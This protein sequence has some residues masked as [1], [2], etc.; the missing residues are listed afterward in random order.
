M[1]SRLTIVAFCCIIPRYCHCLV[2]LHH[3][4]FQNE[5]EASSLI[6]QHLS[7]GGGTV[8]LLEKLVREIPPMRYTVENF[9]WFGFLR[10]VPVSHHT[11]KM[12]CCNESTLHGKCSFHSRRVVANVRFVTYNLVELLLFHSVKSCAVVCIFV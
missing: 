7:A 11:T 12:P 4:L 2:L 3:L 9:K 1:V 5:Y 8:T 6:S 10:F